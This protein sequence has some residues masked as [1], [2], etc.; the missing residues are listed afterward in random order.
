MA[1]ETNGSAATRAEEIA[2]LKRQMEEM[3]K[4]LDALCDAGDGAAGSADGC[5]DG[6]AAKQPDSDVVDGCAHDSAKGDGE[7]LP[8]EGQGE[9][10]HGAEHEMLTVEAV[11]AASEEDGAEQEQPVAAT[12]SQAG[13]AVLDDSEEEAVDPAYAAAALEDFMPQSA[14]PQPAPPIYGAA[15]G[16]QAAPAQPAQP[17]SSQQQQDASRQQPYTAQPYAQAQQ[18]YGQTQQPYGQQPGQTAYYQPNANYYSAPQG[19]YQTQYQQPLIRTKDHVAA[20]LLAI[21]LGVFGVHKFY[22]GYNTAGFILLGVTILGGIFTLGIA[23]SVVWL[24]GVIE[25]VIYLTKGQPEFEQ[26]Y[27]FNKREWF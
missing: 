14:P 1:E 19:T 2:E 24:I 7:P 8:V 20:G 10:Q 13:A 22:L 6:M 3:Q 25:G 12:P 15:Y 18:P 9:A 23:S 16:Q 21:F 27:V 5:D 26:L 4:R 11:P 17:D